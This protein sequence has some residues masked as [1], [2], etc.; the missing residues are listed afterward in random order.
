MKKLNQFTNLLAVFLFLIILSANVKAQTG[1]FISSEKI[2]SSGMLCSDSG[3]EEVGTFIDGNGQTLRHCAFKSNF[4]LN[5]LYVVNSYFEVYDGIGDCKSDGEI[6]GSFNDFSGNIINLCVDRKKGDA[7][8]IQEKLILDVKIVSNCP[9]GHVE[10]GARIQVNEGNIVHCQAKK[11][12]KE[13]PKK[14]IYGFISALDIPQNLTG[15]MD[16]DDHNISKRGYAFDFKTNKSKM[17][18]CSPDKKSVIEAICVNNG[19]QTKKINCPEEKVCESGACIKTG[20]QKM[21]NAAKNQVNKS[22]QI[23]SNLLSDY[24]NK[25]KIFFKNMIK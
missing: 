22:K 5:G 10:S 25:A 14:D 24:F 19:I 18:E 2:I 15:C 1:Y 6:V 11:P 3:F 7:A 9:E 12:I 21:T 20:L 4:S 13:P 23:N 8:G 17:D 16:S